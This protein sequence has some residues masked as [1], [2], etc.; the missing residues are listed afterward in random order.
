MGNPHRGRVKYQFKKED[1]TLCNPKFENKLKLYSHVA[2]MI[3]KLKSRVEG[4][5]KILPRQPVCKKTGSET[6][7]LVQKLDRLLDRLF[8]DRIFEETCSMACLGFE[9]KNLSAK[10]RLTDRFLAPKLDRFLDRL[11]QDRILDRYFLNLFCLS[12]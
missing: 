9:L 10:N 1:G 2:Q 7:F 12:V 11:F 8:W 5:L 6:G 4:L 3:P